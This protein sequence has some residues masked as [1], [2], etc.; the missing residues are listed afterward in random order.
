MSRN[1]IKIAYLCGSRSWG[2][3]EMN[4]FKNA[5]WMKERGHRVV[6]FGLEGS[7]FITAAQESGLESDD[8]EQHRKYYDFSKGKALARLLAKNAVTH[9]IVR[10]N[11]DLSTAVIAKRFSSQKI[12]LSYF[13]EMQLGV[14][15]KSI[16]HTLR[17]RNL[18]V[19]SCPLNW[20]KDQVLT[21]T[22]MPKNRIRVI[23]SGVELNR[24]KMLPDMSTAREKL[25]LPQ[26]AL[27]V[28]LIG[29]FDVHKGQH[30]LIN[31]LRL[32]QNKNV[33]VCLLGESTRGEST[34][35]EQNMHTLIHDFNLTSR[36]HIRP[37]TNQ[38]ETFYAAMDLIV[39]ATQSETV[40]MVT[41]EAMACGKQIIATNTGGSPELLNFGELGKLVE[42]S[43]PQALANEIEEFANGHWKID[44][45]Q[46]LSRAADFDNQT[47]CTVVE[48]ALN[49]NEW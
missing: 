17:Y 42:P 26:D 2:G 14:K 9:L 34:D 18:D 8:I 32:I 46:L 27:L 7:P 47:V 19:W 23:H 41:I 20:L 39:M 1:Q 25:R 16:F 49:L 30:V 28:G 5:L 37:F 48:Q 24:F 21:M 35:Y 13:M 15:K 40:G 38:I 29:R 33:H 6:V 43:N 22:Y 31:A 10:D 4:Q 11:R 45:S 12:H 44:P 36:V 3:L